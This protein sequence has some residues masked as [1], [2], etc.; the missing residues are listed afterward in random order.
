M[1]TITPE[2]TT[3]ADERDLSGNGN[4]HQVILHNDSVNTVD[5]VGK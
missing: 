4:V 1:T 5:Y 2:K 3:V